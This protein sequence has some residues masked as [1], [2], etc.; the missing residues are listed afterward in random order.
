VSCEAGRA[1][2]VFAAGELR[3]TFPRIKERRGRRIPIRV[4]TSE[5]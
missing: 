3:V 2:A 5:A 1:R 4:E